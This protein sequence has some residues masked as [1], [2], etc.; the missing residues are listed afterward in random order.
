MVR[1]GLITATTKNWAQLFLMI[2]HTSL[3]GVL[4]TNGFG[5]GV[6]K[7]RYD[8][9]NDGTDGRPMHLAKV[10]LI[11]NDYYACFHC[12]VGPQE[13]YYDYPNDWYLAGRLVWTS[14]DY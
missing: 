2:C 1:G 13:V 9:I 4:G 5:K 7:I 12:E 14:E 3:I 10:T 11:H 6:M 8:T